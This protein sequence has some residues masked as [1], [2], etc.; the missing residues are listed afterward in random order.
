MLTNSRAFSGFSVDDT[1]A[2]RDF[3]SGTL[4][5]KVTGVEGMEEHGLVTIH[6]GSGADVFVYPKPD[7]TP[8][9]FTI[10]NFPVPDIDEAVDE[11]VRRGV[12]LIRY[13]QFEHDER[14]I[15]KGTPRVAW[16]NDP[17]GN[18]LAVIQIE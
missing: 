5:L 16:F 14:G 9:S 13:E 10:L 3:Y 6:L 17:A 12:E 15:A 8:A 2:A 4:G 7:H 1:Q 18:V 11:L